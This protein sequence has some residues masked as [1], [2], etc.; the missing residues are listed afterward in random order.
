MIRRRR[1]YRCRNVERFAGYQILYSRWCILAATGSLEAYASVVC[2]PFEAGPGRKEGETK[3]NGGD[4]LT[5]H[6]NIMFTTLLRLF[7]LVVLSL[8][9]PWAAVNVVVAVS[10][11]SMP[12]SFSMLALPPHTGREGLRSPLTHHLLVFP[13]YIMIE[14]WTLPG[15]ESSYRS[16]LDFWLASL[17][18]FLLDSGSDA[19]WFEG[20]AYQSKFEKLSSDAFRHEYRELQQN[21]TLP[22]PETISLRTAYRVLDGRIVSY[23]GVTPENDYWSGTYGPGHFGE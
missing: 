17:H 15:G 22:P 4:G 5:G 21:L 14:R 6:G 18:G 16:L 2:C 20:L 1:A 23:M 9:Y 13:E 10:P 3:Q 7:R 12:L 11:Q 8:L 19:R